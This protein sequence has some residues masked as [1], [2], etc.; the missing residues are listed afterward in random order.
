[1]FYTLSRSWSAF[2]FE[3]GG[4]FWLVGGGERID[5]EARVDGGTENTFD[6]LFGMMPDFDRS[7]TFISFFTNR[8]SSPNLSNASE[9]DLAFW[10]GFDVD[11]DR[12]F[13]G[14]VEAFLYPLAYSIC[15][16]KSFIS[17]VKVSGM[18][19]LW[20]RFM[21]MKNYPFVNTPF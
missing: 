9:E 11:E 21:N 6:V 1:M 13:V 4:M 8:L 17:F 20:M 15:L 12:W 18:F 7:S 5:D 3:F 16:T 2:L 14:C 19:G 10:T